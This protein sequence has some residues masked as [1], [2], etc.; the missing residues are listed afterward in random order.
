[1]D[2][3]NIS[4]NA[5]NLFTTKAETIVIPR[6][7]T[8]TVSD[9]IRRDA[10]AHLNWDIPAE[11]SYKNLGEID[12]ISHTFFNNK[13]VGRTV[14]LILVVSVDN[15]FSSYEAIE[16]IA[17][18][19]A[20]R[21]AELST[22]GDI[23][24]P[25]IGAG[26]GR[27]DHLRV[28]EILVKAFF[29]RASD[30]WNLVIYTNN[31][32][33]NNVLKDNEDRI[34]AELLP[35]KVDPNSDIFKTTYLN[36][37]QSTD[38][39]FVEAKWAND[40]KE[41]FI[42]NGIWENSFEEKY[43]DIVNSIK[44]GSNLFLKKHEPNVA[45]TKFM[46]IY[47][48]GIVI[49]NIGN[50]RQLKVKWLFSYEF[51]RK[52]EYYGDT[53]STV[54]KI[55]PNYVNY[56]IEKFP[57]WK[58]NFNV[59]FAY[60][61]EQRNQLGQMTSSL[62]RLNNDAERGEDLLGIHSDVQAFA[63][64]IVYKNFRP[65]LAIALFGKWGSGKS[66]FMNKLMEKV[67]FFAEQQKPE[68]YCEGVAQ[69]HFNAWSY[70][71]ANL[72][73]SLISRI[74]ESLNRYISKDE[75]AKGQRDIIEKSLGEK[76]SL[77]YEE[78]TVYTIKKENLEAAIVK[79]EADK[80]GIDA[81]LEKKI[82]DIRKKSITEVIKK[83]NEEFKAKEK[84]EKAL[85]D[86]KSLVGSADQLKKL[87]PEKYW[88]D[89]TLAYKK[90]ASAATFFKAFFKKEKLWFNILSIVTITAIIIFT[91]KIL[92]Y[93]K[94]QIAGFD[95]S[96]APVTKIVRYLM[97]CYPIVSRLISVSKKYFPLVKSLWKIKEAYE[98]EISEARNISVQE[99]KAIKLD[100]EKNNA[101]IAAINHQIT[102]TNEKLALLEFKKT[103][104]L[105]TEALYHFIENRYS[106]D[107]Y[108]K[109]LGIVSII[110]KDL[111]ILS[112]LFDSHNEENIS[113]EFKKLFD[114]PL[115]RI[116]LY[117]DDLDR[118]PVE[119]VVQVLEAV[120]LLMAFPLFIVVVGV[121][122]NWVK[123]A[124]ESTYSI[125]K[126]SAADYLEKIF[127]VPFHLK[128]VDDLEIKNMIKKLSEVS[129]KPIAV[130]PLPQSTEDSALLPAPTETIDLEKESEEDTG[131]SEIV[132]PDE[133]DFLTLSQTEIQN[134]E[135]MS[136]VIGNNPR[137]VKRFI[138]VY[139]IMRAHEG[140]AFH[141]IEKENEFLNIMFLL[142][143]FF[144]KYKSLCS[145]FLKFM[146]SYG[147]EDR[148]LSEFLHDDPNEAKP[149][150]DA[151]HKLNLALTDQ[152]AYIHLQKQEMNA[153]L[154][155]IDFVNRFTFA[156]PVED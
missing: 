11:L 134:L 146:H 130:S 41:R 22:K 40:Q 94:T 3:K 65:P 45:E 7:T 28:Y 58:E 1:M 125:Q 153:F 136:L 75:L 14:L 139:Q 97:V 99:E 132:T 61:I 121:D 140:L 80:A 30:D 39:Y 131:E 31:K 118:C 67:S 133:N 54:I 76:L 53:S 122:Q 151:K 98:K 155:Y 113:A 106:S 71:D 25:L 72:W 90:A 95:F 85:E 84:I 47:A 108:Q 4:L 78:I 63:R 88:E 148:R 156:E 141:T 81:R 37:I 119:R 83:V 107:E 36:Y 77:S 73:A 62:V 60:L 17:N 5:G 29:L 82:E 91:P 109:H 127:Q 115:E 124:L 68:F 89:P 87:L 105:A 57:G 135:A 111:E 138:N 6:S 18:A 86:N 137:S 96:I 79:L 15:D 123:N 110:R 32:Q 50:G 117:I 70:L 9:K 129:A 59:I 144:G 27:L 74:F 52:A 112:S 19:L 152:P 69:I 145:E 13:G 100:I 64:L 149:V 142:A 66:F 10:L 38:F 35:M 12:T 114:R 33:L 23:A 34:F 126:L 55:E 16:K 154:Q 143:M 120:N 46:E 20:Q 26:A 51:S 116:I 104:A 101:E 24:T 42:E 44:A 147:H 93:L 102:E 43:Y 92:E 150:R 128:P 48:W 56:F 8:G 103:K 2:K 49:S 21:T